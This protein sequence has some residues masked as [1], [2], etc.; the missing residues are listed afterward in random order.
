MGKEIYG[1]R[2]P[3]L[4]MLF[5]KIYFENIPRVNALFHWLC[6]YIQISG[7]TEGDIDGI[8][9]KLDV[10]NDPLGVYV[11]GFNKNIY[12][13]TTQKI[14]SI[15]FH[16]VIGF[17]LKINTPLGSEFCYETSLWYFTFSG[18]VKSIDGAVRE[19][20]PIRLRL[21][22]NLF[23]LSQYEDYQ[24]LTRTLV[25]IAYGVKDWIPFPKEFSDFLD[26]FIECLEEDV[27]PQM[28]YYFFSYMSKD[29]GDIN[30]GN[31]ILQTENNFFPIDKAT[32][33]VIRDGAKN[34]IITYFSEITHEAFLAYTEVK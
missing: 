15:D 14:D 4:E 24:L 3:E 28:K 12:D 9:F 2:Q 25:N 20:H 19:I 6:H 7:H 13:V 29:S 30:V 18:K 17:R 33:M 5:Q 32:E 11:G 27:A 1:F 10:V 26:R 22:V 21:K 34:C 8:T 23:P 31:A 16:N